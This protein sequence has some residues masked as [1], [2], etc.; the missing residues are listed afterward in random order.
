MPEIEFEVTTIDSVDEELRSAYVE[1][2]GKFRFD[3]DK[4]YELKAAPILNKNK[5]LLDEKKK[6]AEEKKSLEKIKES[7]GTD[8]ERVAAEKDQRIAELQ[9]ELRENKIWAPV[10]D[11]AIKS[12]VMP[13][14]LKPFM[15]QLRTDERFDLDDDGKLIYRDKNG[16]L[17]ATTPK[18]AFEI[19]LREE[20]P[21]A[22]EASKA[23]GTGAKN[24]S[25]GSGGR[26]ISRDS[27]DA[28]S[29]L[30]KEQAVKDGARREIG[31]AS[32]RERV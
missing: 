6:L 22:F 25:K 2:D 32:C 12:G 15:N 11:L 8:V 29:P 1:K 14:R 9:R 27:Y 13:D 5:Q 23:G 31:R 16:D 24:G 20:E 28:M 19:Y 4:Y 30:Q 26:V 3:P 17:T 7:A 10:Q 18:R 21:W